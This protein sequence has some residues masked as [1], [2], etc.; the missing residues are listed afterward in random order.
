MSNIAMD[1]VSASYSSRV[2]LLCEDYL[3]LF[4]SRNVKF[5]FSSL[6]LM[7]DIYGICQEIEDLCEESFNNFRGKECHRSLSLLHKEIKVRFMEFDNVMKKDTLMVSRDIESKEYK[8]TGWGKNIHYNLEDTT[9]TTT[10]TT[11]TVT[12]IKY[13]EAMSKYNSTVE[14]YMS[15][16][17]DLTPEQA[18]RKRENFKKRLKYR[19]KLKLRKMGDV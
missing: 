17:T 12:P 11:L 7:K 9:S 1:E 4:R 16:F 15:K 19:E 18:K 13:V 3:D 2:R 10:S 8:V 14:Q 6:R 5:S